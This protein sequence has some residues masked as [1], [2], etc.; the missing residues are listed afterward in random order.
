MTNNAL[1]P[2]ERLEE[3]A[4]KVFY[5]TGYSNTRVDQL[6][7]EAGVF[8]KSF[9]RYYTSKRDLGETYIE[10]QKLHHVAFFDALAKKYPAFEDFWQSWLRFLRKDLCSPGYRGCPF[11]NLANQTFASEDNFGPEIKNAIYLWRDVLE[12][13]L[14]EC[15]FL[16]RPIPRQFV[17]L[18]VRQIMIMYEGSLQMYVMTSDKSMIAHLENTI[19][20]Y[21]KATLKS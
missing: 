9:Y 4:L 7:K 5:Q 11:A 2:K 17:P 8:R 12:K 19:P 20:E 21:F 18:F 14:A 10:L 1:S 13:Y 6:L 3:S 16:K 15:T